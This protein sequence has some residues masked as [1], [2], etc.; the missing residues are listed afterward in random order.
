M[1]K[2]RKQVYDLTP[3]D[4]ERFAVWEYALD[5][6]GV[7]GQDE[8]TVRPVSV[9]DPR[10]LKGR[11]VMVRARFELADGSRMVGYLSPPLGAERDL[12]TTQPAIVGSFGQVTFWMGI[13]R[14]KPSD[15]AKTYKHLGK[16]PSQVFPLTFESDIDLPGGPVHGTIPGFLVIGSYATRNKPVVLK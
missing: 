11:M 4:L 1:K 10:K 2:V 12:G 6:E 9:T 15:L 13:I 16:S 3:A 5:E 7:E 14:P 8:A